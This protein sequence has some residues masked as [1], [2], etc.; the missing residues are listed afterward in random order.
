MQSNNILQAIRDKRLILALYERVQYF[1]IEIKKEYKEYLRKKSVRELITLVTLFLVFFCGLFSVYIQN[2]SNILMIVFSVL[3]LIGSFLAAIIAN[4]GLSKIITFLYNQ[5]IISQYNVKFN[6]VNQDRLGINLI[7][8]PLFYAKLNKLER[9]LESEELYYINN[10]NFFSNKRT[11]EGLLLNIYL[12]AIQ[13]SNFEILEENFDYISNEIKQ[14]FK[15]EDQ[16]I[17]IGTIQNIIS[18]N[19]KLIL[20]KQKEESVEDENIEKEELNNIVE[21]NT[22][23]EDENILKEKNKEEIEEEE[24]IKFLKSLDIDDLIPQQKF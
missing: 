9:E 16:K 5:K 22:I 23:V 14:T 10:F 4:V 19:K 13:K 1:K 11:K 2:L 18:T 20:N 3:M 6:S 24:K 8:N 17:L 15:P 21:S 7:R 12:K